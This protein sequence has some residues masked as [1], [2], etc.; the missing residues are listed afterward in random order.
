MDLQQARPRP[1]E[2][3]EPSIGAAWV[4]RARRSRPLRW[5]VLPLPAPWLPEL[6]VAMGSYREKV[7]LTEDPFALVP[8][9]VIATGPLPGGTT[10][11]DGFWP[12]G[13]NRPV[14][15]AMT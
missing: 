15:S 1:D 2:V 5:I 3:P 10:T 14:G 12:A 8:V 7:V 6:S 11:P 9:M 4:P 13:G